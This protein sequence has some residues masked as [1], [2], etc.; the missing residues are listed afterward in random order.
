[1]NIRLKGS[2]NNNILISKGLNKIKDEY[3]NQNGL[4]AGDYLFFLNRD[5]REVLNQSNFSSKVSNVFKK[6]YNRAIT[7][8]HLRMSWASN[9]HNQNPSV[10]QINELAYKMAHSPEENL[11]YKKIINK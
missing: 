9:L 4:N 3:I 1:M 10:K 5:K 2:I 6:I 7:I 8:R 11:K